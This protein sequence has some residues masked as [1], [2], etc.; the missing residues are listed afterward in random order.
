LK[1]LSRVHG[2]LVTTGW[3]ILAGSA[4]YLPFGAFTLRG[5]DPH[6]VPAIA[7]IG[8]AYLTVVTT[9]IAYYLWTF[10]LHRMEA[11]HV[12]VFTNLQPVVTALL[13]WVFLAEPIGIKLVLGGLLVIAGVWITQR[14]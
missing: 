7:W 13:A 11:A 12:A 5:F 4:L 2:P 14:A 9:V 8:L 10:A 1:P 6:A 3:S